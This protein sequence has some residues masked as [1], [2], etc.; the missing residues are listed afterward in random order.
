[1]AHP[2]IC[3]PPLLPF[4]HADRTA[5][6]GTSFTFRTTGLQYFRFMMNSSRT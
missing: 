1:M 6:E 2:V 4:L 3:G 5:S